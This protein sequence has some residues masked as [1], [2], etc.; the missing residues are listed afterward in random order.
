M[1]ARQIYSTSSVALIILIHGH[2]RS[3]IQEEE[4]EEEEE[5][6][7]KKKKKT[8]FTGT[9]DFNLRGKASKELHWEK[10]FVWC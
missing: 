5:K 6:K 4:E 10:S 1:I 8:L 7:K 2:G 3:S 9:L